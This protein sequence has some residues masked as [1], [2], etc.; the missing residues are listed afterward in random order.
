IETLRLVVRTDPDFPLAHALLALITAFGALMSLIPDTP[1]IREEAR[2]N[3]ER[4]IEL[5]PTG[6]EVVGYAGCAIADLGEDRRGCDL[7]ERAIEIDPSN[8]QARVALGAAQA[9]LK[10]YD[11]GIENLRLGMR[12]SPR[13]SR[14]A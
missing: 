2:K 14:I 13:D 11:K 9:R 10:L 12:L 3:A 7:L 8:A 4:A 1:A 6:S 5:D